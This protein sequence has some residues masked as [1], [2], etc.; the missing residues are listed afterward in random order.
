[1]STFSFILNRNQIT[2]INYSALKQTLFSLLIMMFLPLMANAETVEI[3]GIYYNLINK[4][5]IAEETSGPDN[6]TGDVVISLKC[7]L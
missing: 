5:K 2:Q 7:C 4:A 3:D 6:Y 1:M